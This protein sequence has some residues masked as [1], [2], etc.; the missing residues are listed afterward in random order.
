MQILAQGGGGGPETLRP[1]SST[2][3][4]NPTHPANFKLQEIKD[5]ITVRFGA[6]HL[7]KILFL[8]SSKLIVIKVI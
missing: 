6:I 8:K 1:S 2:H 3:P 7:R 5:Q 4:A